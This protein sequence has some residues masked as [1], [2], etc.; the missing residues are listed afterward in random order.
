MA[1]E[2]FMVTSVP[3]DHDAPLSE[4]LGE[5]RNRMFVVLVALFGLMM[6]SYPFSENA[7]TLIWDNFIPQNVEMFVY[8]PLEWVLA[9]LKLSLVFS[10]AFVFPLFLYEMFTFASSGMYSH[11]RKF[12][13][14]IVPASFLL[15]ILGASV[16]YYLVL[17]FMFEYVIFYSS[18]VAASQ[19]SVQSVL[20]AVTTLVLGFGLIFQLPLVIVLAIKMGIVKYETLKK[21]RIVVYTTV[22]SLSIFISPD[23]TFISQ[24]IAAIV[25]V[26]LFEVGLAVARLF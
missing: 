1:E 9:K 12:F 4:H 10:I 19:I 14:K 20:S 2:S 11:E 8:S 24:M 25:L 16:A 6:V 18:D 17:P 22:L 23:P 21:Q 5:L 15:F 13:I 3:G 26:V 7:L